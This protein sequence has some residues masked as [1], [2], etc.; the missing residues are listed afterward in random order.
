MNFPIFQFRASS[1]RTWEET[2]PEKGVFAAPNLPGAANNE[3][4][5]NN[6][7]DK[8]NKRSRWN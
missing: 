1:D 2:V 6:A 4:N 3:F 5:A 7:N 8:K